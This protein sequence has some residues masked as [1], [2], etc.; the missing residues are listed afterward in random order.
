MSK[1]P[2]DERRRPV[3]RG[4]EE[5]PGSWLRPEL[6]DPPSA[7]APAAASDDEAPLEFEF[8]SPSRAKTVETTVDAAQMM[9]VPDAATGARAAKDPAPPR[10]AAPGAA[11]PGLS[12]PVARTTQQASALF[13]RSDR[14]YAATETSP[15]PPTGAVPPPVPTVPEAPAPVPRTGEAPLPARRRQATQGFGDRADEADAGRVGA[16]SL[17]RLP[18]VPLDGVPRHPFRRSTQSVGGVASPPAIPK[19]PAPPVPKDPAPRGTA[20]I[21]ALGPPARTEGSREAPAI[22]RTTAPVGVVVAPQAAAG[23][24][25]PTA[26]APDRGGDDART[27]RAADP[28]RAA[29]PPSVVVAPMLSL[30]G[31]VGLR[32]PS[33]S[34]L[35][36]APPLDEAAEDGPAAGAPR[37]TPRR[38]GASARGDDD[39]DGWLETPF[40]GLRRLR[41]LLVGGAVVVLGGGAFATWHFTRSSAGPVHVAKPAVAESQ[42]P[43]PKLESKLE[44]K[45]EPKP[46]PKPAAEAR[47]APEPAKEPARAAE[48]PQP[49]DPEPAPTPSAEA[50]SPD[51][52]KAHGKRSSRR[53]Q[54]RRS[55][56]RGAPSPVGRPTPAVTAGAVREAPSPP[57][58]KPEPQGAAA[59]SPRRA[60]PSRRP[61]KGSKERAA[62]LDTTMDP[63]AK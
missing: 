9:A 43:E 56:R 31:A 54:Q 5:R 45:L 41:W 52:N 39:F 61:A 11:A 1:T 27:A 21:A 3:T 58:A 4:L 25:V 63:F 15:R 16:K 13:A 50:P 19:A 55:A 6:T 40:S 26:P 7:G 22:G 8:D 20:P 57:R 10:N 28:A 29:P 32:A 46:E 60:T 24:G 37:R 12:A 59:T 33:P 2:Q 49:P 44:P 23:S 34:T 36:S 62:D 42:K 14:R 30:S 17:P 35:A 48:P 18:K 47:S 51:R 53:F 38:A